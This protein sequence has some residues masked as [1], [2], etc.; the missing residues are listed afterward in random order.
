MVPIRY[1]RQTNL[2]AFSASPSSEPQP[3][4][5]EALGVNDHYFDHFWDSIIFRDWKFVSKPTTLRKVKG[6]S[7]VKKADYKKIHFQLYDQASRAIS[8]G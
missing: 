5:E 8:T 1:C 3:H 7:H 4:M 2:L 6:Q